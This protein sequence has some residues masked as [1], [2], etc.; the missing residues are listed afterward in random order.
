MK[1]EHI[2]ALIMNGMFAAGATAAAVAVRVSFGYIGE[3]LCEGHVVFHMCFF[4]FEAA[5]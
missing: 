2:R 4:F 1:R 3:P 5:S